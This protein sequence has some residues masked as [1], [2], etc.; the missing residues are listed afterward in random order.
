MATTAK[1][2]PYPLGTDPLSQGDDMIHSL[3]DFLQLHVPLMRAGQ[4]V[5]ALNASG[6]FNVALTPALPGPPVSV[7]YTG[8][9]PAGNAPS[10]IRTIVANIPTTWTAA[11]ITGN[12]YKGD[13]SIA[14]SVTARINWAAFY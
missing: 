13:N 10:G 5:V 6:A 7:L 3:A 8:G 9:D 11:L 2:Y 1:G 4:I 14:A 12:A